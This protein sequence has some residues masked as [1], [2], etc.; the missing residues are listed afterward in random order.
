MRRPL[1]EFGNLLAQISKIARLV[2][3]AGAQFDRTGR[4]AGSAFAEPE[5]LRVVLL[6]VIDRFERLRPD[7]LHIPEMKEFVGGDAGQRSKIL[8]EQ[9]GIDFD[10]GGVGVLH[11]SAAGAAREMEEESVGIERTIVHPRHRRGDDPVQGRDDQCGIVVGWIRVDDHTE[12]PA[13]FVEVCLLEFAEFEGRV[14]ESIVVFREVGVIRRQQWCRDVPVRRNMGELD[15][16]RGI[17]GVHG[18]HQQLC[19]IQERMMRVQLRSEWAGRVEV[20]L[21]LD[22]CAGAGTFDPPAT[23]VE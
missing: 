1:L 17:A 14:D 9:V 16:H 5:S 15:F 7:P 20:N 8:L 13:G 12:V 21:I 3:V 11:A 18:I 10:R 23:L 22:D 6:R 19:Q 2:C 4:C